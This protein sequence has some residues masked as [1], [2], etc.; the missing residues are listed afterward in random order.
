MNFIILEAVGWV[1]FL[2][3][4]FRLPVPSHLLPMIGLV[5]L[6]TLEYSHLHKFRPNI[7]FPPNHSSSTKYWSD[8]TFTPSVTLVPYLYTTYPCLLFFCLLD[9]LWRHLVRITI[10]LMD[11]KMFSSKNSEGGGKEAKI[12][13]FSFSRERICCFFVMYQWQQN[14]LGIW[15]V[16]TKRD[17]WRSH[18]GLVLMFHRWI[19]K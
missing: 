6:G 2:C 11:G 10:L 3:C 7:F 16:C 19:V 9:L 12:S 18:L 8:P 14:I 5:H 15:T 1:V 17:N 13:G 4:L